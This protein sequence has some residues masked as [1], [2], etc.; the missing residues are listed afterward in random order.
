MRAE[1]PEIIKELTEKA[2]PDGLRHFNLSSFMSDKPLKDVFEKMDR[3]MSFFSV[4][5]F[6]ELLEDDFW[7]DERYT[8]K[9]E[10]HLCSRVEEE[11]RKYWWERNREHL[12]L[13]DERVESLKNDPEYRDMKEGDLR[14]KVIEDLN[15]EIYPDMIE[16]LKEEYQWMYEDEWEEYWKKEDP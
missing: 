15:R 14:D 3:A 4:Y 12:K 6:M 11:A 10:V 2:E 5:V 16:R 8:E 1:Y 9:E 7:E 13:I